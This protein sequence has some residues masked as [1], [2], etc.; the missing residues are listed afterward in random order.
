MENGSPDFLPAVRGARLDEGIHADWVV[1]ETV[2]Y[3]AV[4]P[5]DASSVMGHMNTP[6]R[7]G[8]GTMSLATRIG[9][10]LATGTR[11]SGRVSPSRGGSSTVGATRDP[12]EL[13]GSVAL[14][15]RILEHRI[16]TLDGVGL[17]HQHF[18]G[19]AADM[20]LSG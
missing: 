8:E 5:L 10:K 20:R 12:A 11:S 15:L 4:L 19:S 16:F 7:E 18:G 13:V 17:G 14:G 1:A 9:P 2:A 6:V 3:V